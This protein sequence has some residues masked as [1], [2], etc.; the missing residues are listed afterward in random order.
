MDSTRRI[1]FAVA[2]SGWRAMFYVRAAMALPEQFELTGVLCHSEEKARAFERAHGVPAFATLEALLHTKPEFVVS[3]VS[4]AGMAGMVARLLEVGMPTLSETPLAVELPTLRAL[5][6]TWRRTGTPLEL[7]EQY[8]LYP[9]H[10]ARLAI[11]KRGLLGDVT[12]CWVSMAHDYHAIA[13]LRA[14]LSP[15]E[16]GVEIRARQTR[17]PIVVTGGRAGFVTDGR[18][19]EEIRTLAEFA[20]ADG[21]RGCYDFS[22]TQYHSAIRSSHI[23]VLGARGEI[24]DD[25]V[26]YVDGESR[27]QQ[28]R[29]EP[30][31]D[32]LSGTIRAVAWQGERVYENPFPADSPM[33]EDDIAVCDVLTRMGRGVVRGGG[34]LYP[35]AFRDAYLSCLLARAAREGTCVRAETM[36]WD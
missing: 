19:C 30:V 18:M 25:T 32:R 1:R 8:P 22:G 20:Y 28:A 23:R 6:E 35:D 14:Y 4:K 36:P 3:C 33:S 34:R 10:A 29:L 21:K 15:D 26:R 9:M 13:L 27:P 7:A 16:R 17:T 24:F 11:M 2:G 5:Y 31:C 12:S